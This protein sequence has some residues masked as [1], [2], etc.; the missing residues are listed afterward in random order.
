MTIDRLRTDA[1]V[2]LFS[3]GENVL[4]YLQ[5]IHDID[6]VLALFMKSSILILDW[7]LTFRYVPVVSKSVTIEILIMIVYFGRVRSVS[8]VDSNLVHEISR[9]FFSLSTLG[10][11]I[12]QP[13]SREAH[14]FRDFLSPLS[15]RAHSFHKIL[16]SFDRS[17]QS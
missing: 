9:S 11:K 1:N 15:S 6:T 12:F 17:L 4:L 3:S 13:F 7:K 8:R 10:K 16:Q 5:T 14:S 2:S